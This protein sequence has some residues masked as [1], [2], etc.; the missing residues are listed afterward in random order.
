MV[1]RKIGSLASRMACPVCGNPNLKLTYESAFCPDCNWGEKDYNIQDC[2]DANAKSMSNAIENVA[3][4]LMANECVVSLKNISMRFNNVNKFDTVL[5]GMEKRGF[6]K[7][8]ETADGE[9]HVALMLVP[10]KRCDWITV[11]V[12]S[13]EEDECGVAYRIPCRLT[14]KQVEELRADVDKFTSDW[15][16]DE[17]ESV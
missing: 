16:D 9:K 6:I 1:M 15:I 10:S 8:F 7:V 12:W 11:R 5:I 4:Y 14:E 13:S 3:A 2:L 17:T